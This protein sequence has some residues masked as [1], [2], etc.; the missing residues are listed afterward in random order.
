M[1][2]EYESSMEEEIGVPFDE[3]YDIEEIDEDCS[4]R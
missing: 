1:S 3:Y 4:E 2:D